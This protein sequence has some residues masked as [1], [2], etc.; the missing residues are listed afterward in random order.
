MLE[1]TPGTCVCDQ[2]PRGD[3]INLCNILM[4]DYKCSYKSTQVRNIT[5][6][7]AF[8]TLNAKYNTLVKSA[9]TLRVLRKFY[10]TEVIV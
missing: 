2:V 4:I 9:D 10:S 6:H 7:T 5:K 1:I 3:S 8:N